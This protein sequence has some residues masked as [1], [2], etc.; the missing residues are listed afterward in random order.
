MTVM[1]GRVELLY[2]IGWFSKDLGGTSVVKYL[3]FDQNLNFI[4]RA[5]LT[6]LFYIVRLSQPVDFSVNKGGLNIEA[7]SSGRTKYQC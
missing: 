3:E 2:F 6:D 1:W 4:I 7:K 5:K